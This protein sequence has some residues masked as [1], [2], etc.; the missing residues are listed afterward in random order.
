[1]PCTLPQ[2]RMLE[3]RAL[4]ELQSLRLATELPKAA[5]H[6]LQNDKM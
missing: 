1:V 3:G 4:E 6:P 2:Y 5:G